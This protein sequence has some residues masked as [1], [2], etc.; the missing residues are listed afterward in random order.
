M[1]RK[2]PKLRK[3]KLHQLFLEG[4]G[5]A[6]L[7]HSD[8]NSVPLLINLKPPFPIALR[9][10]IYNCTNPPGGRALN[11]YKIQIILPGQE[12]GKRA[13]LDYSGGR[14]PLL[15]AYA[16]IADKID[17]GVFILWDAYKHKDF[18]YSANMQVKSDAIIKALSSPIAISKRSNDEI[19]IS[20]R[21]QYLL[22]AIKYR[23]KVIRND[24]KEA[25]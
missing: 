5:D 1:S 18:S 17:D 25:Y 12:R 13:S 23:V 6:V 21:P 7:E 24:V 2:T 15:A 14:M 19:V 4:L 3:H 16:C 22:D 11:E 9:L 10:Y 20:S 8:I